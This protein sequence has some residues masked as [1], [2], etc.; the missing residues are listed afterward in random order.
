MSVID[1]T[2]PEIVSSDMKE[3]AE[4]SSSGGPLP[5]QGNLKNSDTA[6]PSQMDPAKVASPQKE[7]TEP[8]DA[9]QMPQN[10]AC[11]QVAADNTAGEEKPSSQ[12]TSEVEP[13]PQNG[14]AESS[15]KASSAAQSAA[16]AAADPGDCYR[17]E[18]DTCI[19]TDPSSSVEYVYSADKD[20]WVRRDGADGGRPLE[21]APTLENCYYVG[22][23]YCFW[24]AAGT[25]Y[26]LEPTSNSWQRWD[27]APAGAAAGATDSAPAAGD[28][29]CFRGADGGWCCR[30]DSGALCRWD[31]AAGRWARADPAPG[32]GTE[33]RSGPGGRKRRLN[34]GSSDDSE[35]DSDDDD[36]PAPKR[37]PGQAGPEPSEQE[38]PSDGS[39]Y[40]WDPERGAWF[41]KIDEEFLALHRLNYGFDSE[42]R[43]V[44]TAPILDTGPPPAESAP[45]K[46]EAGKQR[47]L[48]TKK[49]PEWFQLDDSK[50]TKVYVSGLPEDVTE[51][52]FV[53]LMSK[54][55]LVMKDPLKKNAWKIKLYRDDYGVPKGDAI[56]TYIKIES[57]D[58]ALSILDGYEFKGKKL[59]V[60][61][62]SFDLK[63]KF[64]P[65]KKPKKRAL[66][67]KDREKL[68]KKQEKLFAWQPDKIR[69]EREKHERVVILKNLFSP[70]E[71]KARPEALLEYQQD[72][73]E[74]CGK[75]GPVRKVVVHDR[76]PDGVAEVIFHEAADADT[77]VQKMSGRYFAGRRLEAATWDGKTKYRVEETEEER[78][79]RL[80][81]WEQ[82]ISGEDKTDDSKP[83]EDKTD[84]SKPAEDKTDDS[85]SAEDKTDDSKPAEDKTDDSKPAEDKTDDSETA[86]DKPT[87]AKPAEAKPTDDRP[88][89]DKP[90]EDR[91]SAEKPS[92]DTP[93]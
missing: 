44:E 64:D 73:R 2:K 18:G 69:G 10:E 55:G 54:C 36:E 52:E 31:A 92:E 89:E 47:K 86:E 38:G 65:S 20:G 3:S 4:E 71:F 60:E 76:H 62:A 67:K 5:A 6:E 84:D 34:R 37:P 46:Q 74:E 30:D 75:C 66:K 93:A 11:E 53:E 63:G 32:G 61:K 41:P 39:G 49:K 45:E 29:R 72:L 14:A 77:C 79:E 9:S 58:L 1:E 28:Q 57:V 19:Y 40:E 48:N 87:E 80:A 70:E 17:Y 85:K 59:S 26:R 13:V 78:A 51:D 81:K 15:S 22:E 43:A 90:N 42:G 23:H 88:A 56:C 25:V 21:T 33:R 7:A 68:Q 24:D 83:A 12:T 82:F 35:H 50:N 8:M 27:D 16:P 91:P